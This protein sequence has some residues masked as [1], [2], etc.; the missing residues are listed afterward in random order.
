MLWHARLGHVGFETVSRA[1]HTGAT[2]GIHL[3]VHTKNCN[4]HTFLLQK[5]SRRPFKGSLVKRASVIGDVIH[6]DFAGPMPPTI[7][8]Y[9]YVQLFIDGRTRLKYIYLLKKKSMLAVR[10]V[11]SSSS[12]SASTIASSS[13]C[14]LTTRQ[15]VLVVISA[16]ASASRASSLPA[17]RRIHRNPTD[18]QKTSIRYFL[19]GFVA[20]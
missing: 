16:A 15:N 5:A 2:T 11:I 8:G 12:L 7:S 17:L 9:T 19:L 14:M 3:T 1:A 4:C 18:S 20:I 13:P 10:C 6:T